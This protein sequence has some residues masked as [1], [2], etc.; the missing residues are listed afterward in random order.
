MQQVETSMRD[1]PDVIRKI[2]N[3]IKSLNNLIPLQETEI[4][5]IKLILEN[6]EKEKKLGM[7]K[8]DEFGS[9]IRVL[10]QKIR[11]QPLTV[12]EGKEYLLDIKKKESDREK[13][14]GETK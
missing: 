8:Y 11:N 4:A 10:E 14:I 5:N 2:E 12:L 1:R 6:L 13:C 9:E 7:E 3:E